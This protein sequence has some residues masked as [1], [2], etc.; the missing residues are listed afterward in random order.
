MDHPTAE[1]NWAYT[2]RNLDAGSF[3]R[4][5]VEVW[6]A[7]CL[8]ESLF[9]HIEGPLGLMPSSGNSKDPKKSKPALSTNNPFVEESYSIQA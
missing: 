1:Y 6:L 4:A 3:E 2:A 9:W 5:A 8:R 7:S